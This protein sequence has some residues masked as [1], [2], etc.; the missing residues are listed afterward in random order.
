MELMAHVSDPQSGRPSGVKSPG[1]VLQIF[2]MAA[3]CQSLKVSVLKTYRFLPAI[4]SPLLPQPISSSDPE[5]FLVSP[6]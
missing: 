6:P 2:N 3:T 4:H 1:C 5:G